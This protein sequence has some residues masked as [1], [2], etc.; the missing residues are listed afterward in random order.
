MKPYLEQQE[1]VDA[2]LKYHRGTISAVTGFGKSITM[3]LLVNALQVRTLIV[4]PNLGLKTQLRATFLDLF[5]TLDNV[6]IENIDSPALKK[7]TDFD[8]LII[9]EAH[10]AAAATYRKLNATA[11]TNIYYRFFFTATPFRSKDA[12][13]LL[14][15]SV[16]GQVI[17][18]VPY[19][20][21]VEK[22]YICP[23]DAY[24]YVTPRKRILKG[25]GKT[26]AGVYSELIVNNAERNALLAHLLKSLYE[27]KQSA[28]CLVKEVAHGKELARLTGAAFAHGQGDDCEQLIEWFAA[29]KLTSLIATMGVCSEGKDTRAAEWILLGAGGQSKNQLMQSI[30]RGVRRFGTKESCKVILIDEPSHKWTH[31]HFREQFKAVEMEYGITPA[32]LDL[33]EDN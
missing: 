28:L 29:G 31:Q 10:H 19:A 7:A 23:V 26:W 14:L 30:G 2:A 11:W 6:L 5:G 12:E 8:C 24:Y 4:V 25:N 18:R 17:Y 33:P 9:D 22:G 3:A 15:E 27:Q 21:A 32:K 13:Q 16:A 20:T 1:I